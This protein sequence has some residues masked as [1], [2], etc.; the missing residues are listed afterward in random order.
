MLDLQR[1]FISRNEKL[2]SASTRNS[3]VPAPTYRPPGCSDGSRAHRSRSARRQPGRRLLDDLLVRRCTR[4]VALEQ[5]HRVAV[6]V[7]E[8]LDLDVPAA[9]DE[10][11][12][13]HVPSPNA[14]AAS[15]S[16]D[17]RVVESRQSRT[18]RMPRPPPPRDAFT[19]AGTPISPTTRPCCRAAPARRRRASALGLD[20]RSHR[21]IAGGGGPIQSDRRRPRPGRT[22]RSR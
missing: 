22:R 13:E 15:R 18:M 17:R 4:A 1:V 19:N 2:P 21:A 9:F 8:H 16:A 6:R 20:L 3:T 10:P 7:G 11:F 14:A 5:R 12:D